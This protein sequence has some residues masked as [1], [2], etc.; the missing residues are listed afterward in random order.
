MKIANWIL[1]F[2]SKRMND[3]YLKR[4]EDYGNLFLTLWL[5]FMIVT[6]VCMFVYPF[7]AVPIMMVVAFY[8]SGLLCYA[9]WSIY[10]KLHEIILQAVEAK[11]AA[12]KAF[13]QL[14]NNDFDFSKVLSD[15]E[16]SKMV[17]EM[18]E[19]YTKNVQENDDFLK[20]IEKNMG[21]KF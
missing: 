4:Y 9:I 17:S 14:G 7:N 21:G 18:K 5:S 13:S 19:H 12:T 1:N 2:I 3:V 10:N 8:L 6:V 20:E 16:F 15:P 11:D